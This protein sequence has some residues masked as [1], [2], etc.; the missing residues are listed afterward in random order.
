LKNAHDVIIYH[1]ETSDAGPGSLKGHVLLWVPTALHVKSETP[2]FGV[3]ETTVN[4]ADMLYDGIINIRTKHDFNRQF[5]FCDI[6]GT[7]WTKYDVP[8]HEVASIAVDALRSKRPNVF[9]FPLCCKVAVLFYRKKADLSM[10]GG[11]IGKEQ[12]M[13]HNET[14]LRML[15]KGAAHYLYDDDNQVQIN[16]IITDG[17]P[18]HRNLDQARILWQ[19]LF[20]EG[21]G[22]NP[23]RDY[24]S[25]SRDATIEHIPSNH[26]KHVIGSQ[27]YINANFLQI[28]DMLLG[29]VIHSCQKECHEQEPPPLGST[30]DSKRD[31]VTTPIKQMLDKT[32]RGSEFKHSGH[33]NSFT[34]SEVEFD[35]KNILFRKIN[36]CH[37]DL[38]LA[39]LQQELDY[40]N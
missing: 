9:K 12:H 11:S 1:D 39:L 28:A 37:V 7:K 21:Q 31:I 30:L 23:L 27:N 40:D 22:R 13:R 6:S 3:E 16:N 35:K 19:L 24:V 29:G 20:D 18:N 14:V 36:P 2:L 25:F 34:V 33:Y 10:Y 32:S 17:E 8:V 38:P 5:H 26:R 4:S 15:L